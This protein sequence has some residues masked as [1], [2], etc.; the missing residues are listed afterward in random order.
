[1][2]ASLLTH[3]DIHFLDPSGGIWSE[4]PFID[5]YSDAM[6]EVMI[7]IRCGLT[8]RYTTLGHHIQGSVGASSIEQWTTGGHGDAWWC[9]IVCWI[10]LWCKSALHHI[11]YTRGVTGALT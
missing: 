11:E 3:R 8:H 5:G 10:A 7:L 6:V 4:D 1:M 9:T 2:V